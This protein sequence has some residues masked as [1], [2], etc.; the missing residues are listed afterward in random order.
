MRGGCQA[1]ARGWG[2]KRRSYLVKGRSLA[3]IRGASVAIGGPSVFSRKVAWHLILSLTPNLFPFT[4]LER[5][6]LTHHFGNEPRQGL[7]AK[8]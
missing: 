7:L 6:W 4:M 8:S 3:G 2:Q 5:D 1:D